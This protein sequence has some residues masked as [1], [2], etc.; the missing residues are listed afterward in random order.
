VPTAVNRKL[1]KVPYHYGRTAT[2]LR[3]SNLPTETDGHLPVIGLGY[4]TRGVTNPD[5][6]EELGMVAC[7]GEDMIIG[8]RQR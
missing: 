6:G 3:C 5:D 2:A 8:Q 4:H 1:V 7:R